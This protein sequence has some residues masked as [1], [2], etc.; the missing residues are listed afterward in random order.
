MVQ[1]SRT[2]QNFCRLQE[3]AGVNEG[4][5][6]MLAAVEAL[7]NTTDAKDVLLQTLMET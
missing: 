3:L 5:D 6:V 4:S 2:E 1:S 7:R